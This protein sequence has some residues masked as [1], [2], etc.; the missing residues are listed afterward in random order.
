MEMQVPIE[1]ASSLA[2]WFSQSSLNNGDLGLFVSWVCIK[3]NEST[4]NLGLQRERERMNGGQAGRQAWESCNENGE[5]VTV[6]AGKK[7][8]ESE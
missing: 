6:L 4:K 5:I 3:S 2:S 8:G 1:I 7:A